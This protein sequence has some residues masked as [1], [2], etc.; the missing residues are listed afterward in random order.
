[1]LVS[2]VLARAA[3]RVLASAT[4]RVRVVPNQRKLLR[5]HFLLA[6]LWKRSVKHSRD[7]LQTPSLNTQ[8]AFFLTSKFSMPHLDRLLY[9]ICHYRSASFIIVHH[10]SLSFHGQSFAKETAICSFQLFTFT[11]IPRRVI[12]AHRW[13]MYCV[14][15]AEICGFS[16]D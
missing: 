12:S 1:M 8:N 2:L 11:K 10:R 3:Y 13:A 5:E 7:K 6:K 15:F 16:A 9:S 4:V 14:E